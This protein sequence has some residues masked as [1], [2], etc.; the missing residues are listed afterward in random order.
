MADP[1]NQ[2]RREERQAVN[3]S[4]AFFEENGLIFQEVDLRSDIG[5]DAILDLSRS[6][7]DAG[8]CVA[9][10]IKGGKKYKRGKRAFRSRRPRLHNIWLNSS[11]P[12]F[13]IVGDVARS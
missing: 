11:I 3:A 4:Q 5:K 12:I 10:Q 13:V 8:L 6:G 1:I 9:P 2:S 7:D